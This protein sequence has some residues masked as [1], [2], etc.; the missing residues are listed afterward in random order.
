MAMC[1]GCTC[2]NFAISI[3]FHNFSATRR[4]ACRDRYDQGACAEH[5]AARSTGPYRRT[6][7]AHLR[8]FELAAA[9][10]NTR[11]L[12]FAGGPDEVHREAIA[13][14]ELKKYEPPGTATS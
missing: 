10:A 13:R 2:L 12:R 11:T 6:A 5:G 4:R 9:W 3:G 7:W 14:L 8:D 1:D